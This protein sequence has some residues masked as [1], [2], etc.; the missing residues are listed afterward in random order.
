VDVPRHDADLALVRRDHAR[1]VRA[2][3]ARGAALQVALGAHHVL[4]RDA[5]GDADDEGDARLGRL[6]DRVGGARRRHVDD[7]GVGAGG[8]HGLA[9]GVEDRQVDRVAIRAAGHAAR[10]GRPLEAGGGCRRGPGW[11]APT[12]FVP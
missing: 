6:H 12:I 7:A 10:V 1:A 3:Q 5:L 9:H 2:D 11:T 4:D 8:G